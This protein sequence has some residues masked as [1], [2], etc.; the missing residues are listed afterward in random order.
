MD[1]NKL[2]KAK[3][4]IEEFKAEEKLLFKIFNYCI[5]YYND[6]TFTDAE[7]LSNIL[8]TIENDDI[9]KKYEKLINQ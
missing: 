8:K 1:S 6:K 4:R 5:D 9:F 3:D 2:I 7:C